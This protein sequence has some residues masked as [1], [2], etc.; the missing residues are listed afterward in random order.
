MT[1]DL[2]ARLLERFE[3]PHRELGAPASRASGATWR[4]RADALGLA[5]PSSLVGLGEAQRGGRIFFGRW[6]LLEPE[7]LDDLFAHLRDVA[8]S[9]PCLAPWTRM[10]P[11]FTA[12]GDL[13]V[14][15]RDGAIRR[16]SV[17]SASV[18]EQDADLA[19]SL[20]GLLERFLAGSLDDDDEDDAALAPRDSTEPLDL[21]W[22]AD[23]IEYS[24]MLAH[25][26]ETRDGSP[27]CVTTLTIDLAPHYFRYPDGPG[28]R[29]LNGHVERARA[30]LRVHFEGAPLVVPRVTSDRV[31]DLGERRFDLLALAEDFLREGLR[32]GWTGRDGRVGSLDGWESLGVVPPARVVRF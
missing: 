12:D 30:P 24:R 29:P 28:S 20:D 1:T 10:L 31:I 17:A 4:E 6:E 11:L 9:A 22:W 27:I 21:W 2:V 5:C 26:H 32:R 19:P 14:L 23:G 18:Y 15:S 8:A 3:L 7:T 25:G 13:L 16:A